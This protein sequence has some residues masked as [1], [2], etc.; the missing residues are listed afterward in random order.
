MFELNGI[1]YSI[2]DLQ[3]AA[4]KYGMDFDSYLETFEKEDLIVNGFILS[5]DMVKDNKRLMSSLIESLNPEVKDIFPL[6]YEYDKSQILIRSDRITIDSNKDDIYISSRKDIH[7]GSGRH[8]GISTNGDLVIESNN[9]YLGKNSLD[10][11]RDGSIKGQK[12]VL[13]DALL[14]VLK[15]TLKALKEASSLFYGS[16]IPLTD[17]TGSPLSI[18]VTAIEQKIDKILSNHHYIEPNR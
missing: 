10:K 13:G 12:M 11:N 4:S 16:P 15:D 18:K 3:S 2:Q 8:M 9:T 6:I 1:E 14:D 5:S 7:I 17:K